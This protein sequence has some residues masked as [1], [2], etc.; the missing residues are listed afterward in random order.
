ME[1]EAKLQLSIQVCSLQDYAYLLDTGLHHH[2]EQPKTLTAAANMFA[3][4][5]NLEP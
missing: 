5:V 3:S 4:A 2:K 1:I